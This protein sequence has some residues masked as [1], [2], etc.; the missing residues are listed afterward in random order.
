MGYAIVLFF[1]MLAMVEPMLAGLFPL[2]ACAWSTIFLVALWSVFGP[3]NYLKR[4]LWA[5]LMGAL[6]GLAL[7]LGSLWFWIIDRGTFDDYWTGLVMILISV[8]P[9]SL[10]AQLPFWFFRGLFGW[11]LVYRDSRPA[12]SFCLRDI[13]VLT[14][15]FAFCFS[16]PQIAVNLGS[17]SHDHDGL[18]RDGMTIT[19]L[20][21][22]P[23]GSYKPVKRE[24]TASDVDQLRRE[25][26]G[27]QMESYAIYGS[28]ML[29]SFV[30]SL[31]SAPVVL[32]VFRS[33]EAATGCGFTA[34][35]VFCL[36]LIPIAII[37]I[38]SNGLGEEPK[39]FLYLGLL[40]TLSVGGF[41]VPLTVSRETGF[42]LTSSKRFARR[43]GQG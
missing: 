10:G 29:L 35:Y 4:M 18:P 27:E 37:T 41:A 39:F 43:H 12:R 42:Q 24:L 30:V 23:D 17:S 40:L 6:P 22:Q 20:K 26:Q 8:V 11:Q 5:H 32:F 1:C 19:E 15:V 25:N 28:I 38:A 7:I 13:F 14:F 34:I 16:V 21:I 9:V 3:G 36:W 31:L 33:P 2:F